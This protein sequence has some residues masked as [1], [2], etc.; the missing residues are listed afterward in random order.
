MVCLVSELDTHFLVP[1][2]VLLSK[3]DIAELA[4]KTGFAMEQMPQI[5]SSDPAI[6][7][8]KAEPGDIVKIIR[9]SPTAG[10]SVYYRRVID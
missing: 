10:K 7:E 8:M 5:L 2:H 1:K 3:Q 6:K 4:E 9:I